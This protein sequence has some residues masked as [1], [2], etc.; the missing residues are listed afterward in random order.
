MRECEGFVSTVLR[1][2]KRN[3]LIKCD[4]DNSPGRQLS[5]NHLLSF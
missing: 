1:N 4:D 2:L 3:D 5:F